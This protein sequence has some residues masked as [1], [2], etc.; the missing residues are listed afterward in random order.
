MANITESEIEL[1]RIQH[2]QLIDELAD[3]QEKLAAARKMFAANDRQGAAVAL[4][5]VIDYLKA[6]GVKEELSEPLLALWGAL[7]D[8]D[9]GV[10]NPLTNWEVHGE[11]TPEQKKQ[12]KRHQDMLE[13]ATAAAVVS[14]LMRANST[15]AD[16]ER[17]VVRLAVRKRV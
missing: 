5:A 13:M 3:V 7:A 1:L 16:A 17:E 8:A 14:I 10:R 6:A 4:H 9:L 12:N 11:L 15:Q 2:N